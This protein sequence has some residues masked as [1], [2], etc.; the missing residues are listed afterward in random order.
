MEAAMRPEIA[1]CEVKGGASSEDWTSNGS[2]PFG[3]RLT[4]T[5]RYKAVTRQYEAH[6]LDNPLECEDT[7]AL[8]PEPS[9]RQLHAACVSP[10]LHTLYLHGGTVTSGAAMGELWVFNRGSWRRRRAA[11]VGTDPTDDTHT[12]HS[13][14]L[15]LADRCLYMF[16][17]F[18]CAGNLQPTLLK[19]DLRAPAARSRW[20]V[21]A[22]V[23]EA[24]YGCPAVHRHSAVAFQGKLW[25]FGGLGAG[26]GSV[27]WVQCYDLRARRWVGL[28]AVNQQL[29]AGGM[30]GARSK[31]GGCKGGRDA[32]VPSP[33]FSHTASHVRTIEDRAEMMVFGGRAAADAKT[34]NNETFSYCYDSLRWTKRYT[35]GTV[36]ARRSEHAAVGFQDRLFVYGGLGAAGLALGDCF[37]L[38]LVTSTWRQVS[39]D[40]TAANLGR[41]RAMSA[42]LVES[43]DGVQLMV[44]GGWKQASAHPD[45]FS[46]EGRAPRGGADWAL[47]AALSGIAGV[48]PAEDAAGGEVGEGVLVGIGVSGWREKAVSLQKSPVASPPGSR[49][50][51]P[52]TYV[53]PA[54]TATAWT[55]STPHGA[56]RR[57][58]PRTAPARP[59][60]PARPP[61]PR[62]QAAGGPRPWSVT[63]SKST[64]ARAFGDAPEPPAYAFHHPVVSPDSL[65]SII[66]RLNTCKPKPPAGGP[67]PLFNPARRLR[68]SEQAEFVQRMYHHQLSLQADSRRA[69]ESK[70]CPKAQRTCLASENVQDMVA[71]LSALPER[72]SEGVPS[73]KAPVDIERS[74]Q[75]LYYDGVAHAKDRRRELVERC[76]YKR[77]DVKIPTAAVGDL[78]E[79]LY[80]SGQRANGA[81]QAH[82]DH[83]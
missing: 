35:G 63:T 37:F 65:A 6:D 61:P 74:V 7:L 23:P 21:E 24:P 62:A 29:L 53:S 14:T 49:G 38:N 32:D 34:A 40:A 55:G 48:E 28:P 79:R 42:G 78:V 43:A 80:T 50:A 58:R 51:S 2:P 54:S 56:R 8:G 33:R 11:G 73:P 75:R 20:Q 10:D 18:D 70:Y 77:D 26:A 19:L 69:L 9:E 13:H 39:L 36:P 45:V 71:R 17:G 15:S 30:G 66:V 52:R 64:T 67:Q 12:R 25:F 1:E 31:G 60:F 46:G 83:G 82:E 57:S 59:V 41:R 4:F 76:A 27:A 68:R 3:R 72:R 22:G 47:D 81:A 16:G 5:R 44:F